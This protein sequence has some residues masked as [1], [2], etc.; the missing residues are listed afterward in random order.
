METFLLVLTAGLAVATLAAAAGSLKSLVERREDGPRH[1]LPRSM[2][3]AVWLFGAL[4]ATL[5]IQVA[6]TGMT[7]TMRLLIRGTAILAFV[8]IGVLGHFHLRKQRDV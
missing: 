7:D 1:A 3:M 8:L 2:K 4:G 6:L 5:L